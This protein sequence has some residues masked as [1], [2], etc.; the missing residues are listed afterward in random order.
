VRA[1]PIASLGCIVLLAALTV[2]AHQVAR[3]AGS[4]PPATPGQLF[5][6][7]PVQEG[8]TTLP[9]GHFNFALAPGESIADGI[10]VENFSD[11]AL[12][13][14]VYGA[15]LMTAVGGGLAPAQPTATMRE[16]GAWIT[17]SAPTVT[18][19]AH[20]EFIDNF[21]LRLPAAVSVGEHLGAVVVAADVGVTPQRNPIE[22]RT[23][24]ITVITVPGI[25]R[26]S[27]RLDSLIGSAPGSGQIE[28]GISL[29]NTG[30]V[31]LTYAASLRIDD[32][33]GRPVATLALTPTNAYV[34]PG[35]RVRLASVW[36]ESAH[37]SDKYRAQATVTILADGI[38]VGTLMSQSLGLRFISAMPILIA[39][40]VAVALVLII[41]LAI[42]AARRRRRRRRRT[43]SRGILS[44]RLGGAR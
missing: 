36:T 26:P 38:P 42:G 43:I 8:R 12:T 30:N 14:H 4:S 32:G 19:V 1:R 5:G 33:D 21:T 7:H 28:F 40:G 18:I 6:V 11:R 9:G 39:G 25:A 27:A 29:S 17:V 13:F 37:L 23:A 20:G 15:D 10:V 41:L 2:G 44:S 34:V 31:L 16:A 22:A 3:A 24:L 35:G